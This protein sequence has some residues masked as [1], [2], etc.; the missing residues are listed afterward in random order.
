MAQSYVFSVSNIV[1]A[2]SFFLMRYGS[3]LSLKTTEYSPSD[4]TISQEMTWYYKDQ[5]LS[6]IDYSTTP[7]TVWYI[8]SDS[9]NLTSDPTLAALISIDD[10]KIKDTK[11]NSILINDLSYR[12][13]PASKTPDF[14]RSINSAELQWKKAT[15]LGYN[16]YPVWTVKNITNGTNRIN[17][18]TPSGLYEL[19]VGGQ[20]LNNNMTWETCVTDVKKKTPRTLWRYD[21]SEGTLSIPTDTYQGSR[22][23]MIQQTANSPSSTANNPSSTSST[24]SISSTTSQYDPLTALPLTVPTKDIYSCVPYENCDP[25]VIDAPA[26]PEFS[27]FELG[28][29]NQT[30]TL[31]N[32]SLDMCY[33]LNL[34]PVAC[35][36]LKNCKPSFGPS[37]Y[38]CDIQSTTPN[39]KFDPVYLDQAK[40]NE[41]NAYPIIPGG[42][43]QT[44]VYDSP[45]QCPFA[46]PADRIVDN[47]FKPI[48]SSPPFDDTEMSNCCKGLHIVQKATPAAILS[49]RSC[50][51]DGIYV[52]NWFR[53]ND[54]FNHF[55]YLDSDDKEPRTMIKISE[56]PNDSV[57]VSFTPPFS[58]YMN[59]KNWIDIFAL[60]TLKFQF[61]SMSPVMDARCKHEWCPWSSVCGNSTN[62]IGDYCSGID[63]N[64]YPRL[65]TD[66]NCKAWNT[67]IQLESKSDFKYKDAGKQFCDDY[68]TNYSC[69]CEKIDQTP[70]YRNMISILDQN[71]GKIVLPKSVCWAAPCSK[72]DSGPDAKI[73]SFQN[74]KDS[75]DCK[76]T[77]NVCQQIVNLRDVGTA[78]IENNT[79]KQVCGIQDQTSDSKC[80]YDFADWS[81]CN[82]N[83]QYRRGV[84]TSDLSDAKDCP[85]STMQTQ[86][87]GEINIHTDPLTPTNPPSPTPSP[88]PS[89]SPPPPD[90]TP[91]PA[92]TPNNPSNNNSS[93]QYDDSVAWEA[94]SLFQ[95][96]KQQP[97][98]NTSNTSCKSTN[99]ITRSCF[100]KNDKT[101]MGI[102]ITA[103]VVV[104]LI[105]ILFI[106][107]F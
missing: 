56:V 49:F 99:T 1:I 105:I 15:D 38:S 78:T 23:Y 107:F 28:T 59:N 64:G 26:V 72:G 103:G 86:Q 91:D 67:S 48:P 20:C 98:V 101:M 34:K 51:P 76:V 95:E 33:D 45:S 14:F 25:V 102:V 2:K 62:V 94:C 37:G 9:I 60:G 22:K 96:K 46:T 100:D 68:P 40:I 39:F 97:L 16:N 82:N 17:T 21:A 90:P 47:D 27:S 13:D 85:S 80:K 18:S 32:K 3:S 69:T 7:M 77:F 10:N 87:C 44:N 35:S 75:A 88:S 57:S 50:S 61:Y 52:A 89:P 79:F 5:K 53:W 30:N 70:Y 41:K 19:S 11:N 65:N 92:P 66:K 12:H 84:L 29:I 81:S 36:S 43:P 31:Y 58:A 4:T 54:D 83:S 74:M 106:M 24:S 55:Y 6:N 71:P 63:E 104:L 73:L 93:C 8:Q 42:N